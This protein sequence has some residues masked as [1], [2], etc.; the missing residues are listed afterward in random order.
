MKNSVKQLSVRLNG[1][2]VGIFSQTTTGRMRFK[3]LPGAT[4]A[5]SN[6]LPIQGESYSHKAC[7]AYF[8]GLLPE[9][10]RAKKAIALDFGTSK[11]RKN[12]SAIQKPRTEPFLRR[13]SFTN[14]G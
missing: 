8:A 3:Y 14:D 5:I 2:P 1:Q 11:A 7:E 12:E 9:S 10:S 13:A 4:R 6:S